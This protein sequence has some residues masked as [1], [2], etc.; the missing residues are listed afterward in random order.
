VSFYRIHS[1]K[2]YYHINAFFHIAGL[3]N[4]YLNERDAKNAEYN[5]KD[6]DYR[7]LDNK[8]NYRQLRTYDLASALRKLGVSEDRIKFSKTKYHNQHALTITAFRCGKDHS[9][10]KVNEAGLCMCIDLDGEFHIVLDDDANHFTLEEAEQA[11]D[12]EFQLK[13][14]AFETD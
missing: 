8:E 10:Y 13:T 14:I 11:R 3:G 12:R 9:V 5:P 2:D 1:F 4:I 6:V 7:Y